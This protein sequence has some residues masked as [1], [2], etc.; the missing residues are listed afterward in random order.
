MKNH[1]TQHYNF[2]INTI[3][4]I[5][6]I[7]TI[8]SDVDGVLTDG[9]LHIDANGNELFASFNI[10]DG[11]GIKIAQEHNMQFIILSGKYSP[12][13]INRFKKLD[14]SEIY[15]GIADKKSKL[16]ELINKLSLNKNELAYIGDDLID[17]EAMRLTN[18]TVAPSN[19]ML[20][21]KEYVDINLI[22]SGGSGALRELIDIILYFQNL[23]TL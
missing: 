17:L 1:I 16:L 4:K 8:I 11:S 6:Q 23:Q 18:L 15:T 22:K 14:I 21:I 19:A 7:K 20:V 2:D 9:N 12:I 3:N 5:K 10:Y 13:T